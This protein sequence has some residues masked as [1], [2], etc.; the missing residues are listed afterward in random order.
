LTG[1]AGGLSCSATLSLAQGN[2]AATQAKGLEGLLGVSSVEANVSV[3]ELA[4]SPSVVIEGQPLKLSAV[5]S[6]SE[7]VEVVGCAPGNNASS[8]SC[9]VSGQPPSQVL[10]CDVL[11][12]VKGKYVVTLLAASGLKKEV[13]VVLNPGEK[14]MLA[15]KALDFVYMAFQVLIVVL[16]A[17]AILFG[18]LALREKMP[19]NEKKKLVERRK[20]VEDRLAAIQEE[21]KTNKLLFM[22]G[23]KTVEQYKAFNEE[24]TAE[25]TALQAELK[26][27]NERLEALGVKQ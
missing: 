14:A 3:E 25:Q 2:T 12:P 27:L 1:E 8:C 11:P 22:K 15:P 19:K 21:F 26:R 6:S 17:G 10:D 16:V 4:T 13:G 18:L 20:A 24:R 23:K 7:S 5:L 9:S